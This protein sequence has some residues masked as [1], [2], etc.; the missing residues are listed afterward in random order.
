MAWAPSTR[1]VRPLPV[2]DHPAGED[3]GGWLEDYLLTNAVWVATLTTGEV[4]VQDD[5]RPG[6]F[7]PSAWLRLQ[8]RC[9]SGGV[10]VRRLTLRFRDREEPAAPDGAQAYFFSKAV[11]AG[12]G[13]EGQ[14]LF[15]LAGWLSDGL[16]QV[17]RWAV[18]ELILLGQET[19]PHHDCLTQLIHNP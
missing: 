18:P 5:G 2:N 16:V 11:A 19:R 8:Q 6:R 12:L 13:Q 1:K 7:P 3:C 9:K 15:Y 10:G 4:V 14:Q 17:Q